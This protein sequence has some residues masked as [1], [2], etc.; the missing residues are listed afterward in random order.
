M[1][2]SLHGACWLVRY[3]E[4]RTTTSP[5]RDETTFAVNIHGRPLWR[6]RPGDSTAAGVQLLF[7]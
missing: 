4:V 5:F 7:I 2:A 6:T 3:C 1:R